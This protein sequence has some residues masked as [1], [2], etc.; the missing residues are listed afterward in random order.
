MVKRMKYNLWYMNNW[1]FWVD[2]YIIPRTFLT[3]F[4]KLIK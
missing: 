2:I 1:S 4:K 3:I